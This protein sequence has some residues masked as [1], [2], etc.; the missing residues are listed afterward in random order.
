[1]TEKQPEAIVV[2]HIRLLGDR[3]LVRLPVVIVNGVSFSVRQ[4][5]HFVQHGERCNCGDCLA[6]R[7]KR[8]VRDAQPSGSSPDLMSPAQ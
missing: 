5:A 7:V 8:A 2:E 1:M 6:C 3:R 4:T